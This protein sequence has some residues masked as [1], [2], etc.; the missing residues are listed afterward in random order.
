M[1]VIGMGLWPGRIA[2][3]GAGGSAVGA[4]GLGEVVA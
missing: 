4:C 1:R 3:R 2:G